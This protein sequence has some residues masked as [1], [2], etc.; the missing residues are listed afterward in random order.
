MNGAKRLNCILFNIITEASQHIASISCNWSGS[1]VFW[2][3]CRAIIIVDT[4]II[5]TTRP[6]PTFQAGS[7]GNGDLEDNIICRDNFRFDWL[8]HWILGAQI[9]ICML[10]SIVGFD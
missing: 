3:C 8:A 9:Q 4:L 7:F 5:R 2:R 10:A 6:F 1:L